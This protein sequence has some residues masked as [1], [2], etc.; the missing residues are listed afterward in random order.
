[1]V[2]ESTP[3]EL[4]LFDKVTRYAATIWNKTAGVEGLSNDPRM[5]SAMLFKRLWSNHRGYVVLWK[6]G[7]HLEADIVLRSG[8]EASICIAA[9]HHLRERFVQR[10]HGDTIY[11]LKSQ[12]K[13]W[14]EEGA[15]DMVRLCEATLRDLRSRFSSDTKPDRLRW[16]ELAKAGQASHLY[17]WHRMLSGVSS[18]VTG[19]SVLPG[20]EDVAD[21][22]ATPDIGPHQRKMHL[23]MMAGATLTGCLRHA[24]TFDDEPGCAEAV[25]LMGKLGDLSWDWPGVTRKRPEPIAATAQVVAPEHSEDRRGSSEGGSQ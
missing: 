22:S 4:A 20:V 5:F 23:M 11:T 18:H 6:E 21:P 16:E 24:G 2:I 25:D 12:I 19:V 1:M 17:G 13:L 10:M 9:C 15:D 7:L 14:R 8:I 3:H